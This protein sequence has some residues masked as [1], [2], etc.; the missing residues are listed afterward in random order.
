M[1]KELEIT[2]D[3]KP[4]KPTAPQ[5]RV[6]LKLN[7]SRY[8]VD[9]DTPFDALRRYGCVLFTKETGQGGYVLTQ[10]GRNALPA[11]K[12]NG[13]IDPKV[14][15]V[16]QTYYTSE[17]ELWEMRL[18]DTF[19]QESRYRA[20]LDHGYAS[21][22]V[23]EGYGDFAFTFDPS[24][25]KHLDLNSLEMAALFRALEAFMPEK[26]RRFEFLDRARQLVGVGANAA[27]GDVLRTIE[28]TQIAAKTHL[29]AVQGLKERNQELEDEIRSLRKQV[30]D[31]SW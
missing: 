18:G 30:E 31:L 3:T 20:P 13:I 15:A 2:L 12:G 11:P 25:G 5:T 8:V 24:R 21:I 10:R 6:L 22:F 19:Q 27:F 14:P 28:N 7:R 29:E 1:V 16:R 9:H 17:R 23:Q 26:E 4:W